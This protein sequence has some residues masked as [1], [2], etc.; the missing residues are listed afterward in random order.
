[1]LINNLGLLI[2]FYH[3]SIREEFEEEIAADL[4]SMA[5]EMRSTNVYTRGRFLLREIIGWMQLMATGYFEQFII[6]L[7]QAIFSSGFVNVEKEVLMGENDRWQIQ[8]RRK[9]IL[10]ALPMVLFG[11]SITLTWWII[12]GPWY[13]ATETTLRIALFAGLAVAGLIALEG[14][15]CNPEANPKLG[16]YISGSEY[17]WSPAANQ[18]SN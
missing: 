6:V 12:G 4:Q 13:E 5:N 7:L 14:G 17:Y 8:D 10:A 16:I 2:R 3:R 11:F 18:R 9:A 1:M 15:R